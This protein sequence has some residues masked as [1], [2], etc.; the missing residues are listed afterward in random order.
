MWN[1]NK[2]QIT[3]VSEW[4]D[5]EVDKDEAGHMIDFIKTVKAIEDAISPYKEQ[6]KDIKAEYKENEWL[7]AKQQRMAIK[8]HRMIKDDVDMDEFI[9]LFNSIKQVVPS[10]GE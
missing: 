10:G 1:N 7:D 4:N 5:E 6:L 3:M 9:D 2:E 8:I